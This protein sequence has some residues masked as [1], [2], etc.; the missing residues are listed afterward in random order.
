MNTIIGKILKFILIVLA[1]IFVLAM[2]LVAKE[3]MEGTGKEEPKNDVKI[4]SAKVEEKEVEGTPYVIIK[5]K[6]SDD[7]REV[8]IEYSYFDSN[9]YLEENQHLKEKY[10]KPEVAA[11]YFYPFDLIV[12]M[13]KEDVKKNKNTNYLSV[14]IKQKERADEDN[15]VLMVVT[16]KKDEYLKEGIPLK[17]KDVNELNGSLLWLGYKVNRTG[18]TIGMQPKIR[19]FYNELFGY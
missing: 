9:K 17:N 2:F 16:I 1:V 15:N 13:L 18:L 12:D 4:E 14:T 5:D 7:F 6:I 11:Y 19:E 8:V 3:K 10:D